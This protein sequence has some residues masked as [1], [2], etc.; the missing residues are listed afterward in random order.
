MDSR[1]Y[2]AVTVFNIDNEGKLVKKYPDSKSAQG[3]NN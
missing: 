3:K 2:S 1:T